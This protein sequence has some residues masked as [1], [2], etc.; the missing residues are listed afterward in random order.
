M[1]TGII[2]HPFDAAFTKLG[3]IERTRRFFE[4]QGSDRAIFGGFGLAN[5][6]LRFWLFARTQSDSLIPLNNSITI[7]LQPGYRT[8]IIGHYRAQSDPKLL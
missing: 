7:P 8:L 3:T 6:G 4:T 1:P 5:P 2:G